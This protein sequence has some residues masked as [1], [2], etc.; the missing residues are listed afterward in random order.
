MLMTKSRFHTTY[1]KV[2]NFSRMKYLIAIFISTFLILDF[3]LQ[4]SSSGQA[5]NYPGNRT[6]LASKT[7]IELPI[8]AIRPQGWLKEQLNRMRT[9]MTGHLDSIYPQVAG[10]RNGWLG[11]DGDVW[12]RGP[13]WIDGLL[14]LAYI[15]NDAE[16][17]KKIKPWIEWTLQSQKPNGYFGPDTDREPEEG[18]Q[19]NNSHDW[20]PK[21]VMLKVMQQ[22]YSATGDKRIIPFMTNY[23]NY[24]LKELPNHPL[25]NWTFWGEQ[26][27]GDNLMMVYWLY[28]ITGDPFLLELGELIHEQ[29]FNWTDVFLHQD[30][31]SRQHSLHCVNLG[32]GFKEP[33]I[34]FQ[35]NQNPELLEAV[36]K[37]VRDMRNTIGLPIGLWAGDELLRFGNPVQGSELCTAVEMMYSLESILQVTGDVQWA[38]H[39]EKIAYNALP[40]QTTDDFGARQ[41]YQQVNQIKVSRDMRNFVTPHHDTDNLFGELTGYPCCTSNMHQGWP[42]FTQN[43]WYATND[44]G[45]AALIYAPS[46]VSAKVGNGKLITVKESTQYP[47]KETITFTFEFP[48]REEEIEFPFHLRIPRWC[49]NPVITINGEGVTAETRQGEIAR[50][51]RAWKSNDKV[52]LRLPMEVSIS[53]WYDGGAAVERG[54]LLYALKMN[55][56]WQKKT[57]EPHETKRY[58]KWYYQV[59]SDSPWNYA[60]PIRNL[61]KENVEKAFIVETKNMTSDYPWTL[62]NAPVTIKTKG[63]RL[64][65][66]KEYDGSAGPVS[67]FL[68]EQEKDIGNEENIELIPYGCS[69]LRIAIFPVRDR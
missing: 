29:T 51:D 47:F 59:T 23:F 24:Q 4:G 58:G 49:K 45:I 34:Y 57:T 62:Q 10:Q 54:P 60:L 40:T 56:N 21:M 3:H 55:E 43:L 44:N 6:P 14:P 67:Y 38:D 1:F 48:D 22:Y 25:G 69:T 5:L 11:G 66:W 52:V 32:Q 37:A 33:V 30:H 63:L 28:N 36:K 12:E 20:W 64:P 15:M 42:K 46:E 16:L 19:R 8:G 13:Y 27:G 35:Q 39:L 26:R 9:G 61:S 18:L 31:L 41:Y 68:T 17:K 53:R 65:G 7:Y 50:I 2:N